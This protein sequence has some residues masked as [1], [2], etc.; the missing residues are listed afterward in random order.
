MN[1]AVG[2]RVGVHDVAGKLISLNDKYPDVV[3]R[4]DDIITCYGKVIDKLHDEWKVKNLDY[5][6]FEPR[7][8][9][10]KAA[11]ESVEYT[12]E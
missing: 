3:D 8:T 12:K 1:D 10:L 6:D 5:P 7:Q 9:S 11:Q 4:G 2:I